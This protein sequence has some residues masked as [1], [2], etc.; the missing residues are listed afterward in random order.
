MTD[1]LT[2]A[3]DGS[4][5]FDMYTIRGF[6]AYSPSSPTGLIWLKSSGRAKSGDYAGSY[7][8]ARGY[9]YV[10]IAKKK[11]LTHRVV[12]AL[13]HGAID[14][15]MD[16]DHKDGNTS[17]NN[18]GNLRAAT[19]AENLKNTPLRKDNS[20][21]VKGLSW[22]AKSHGWVGR[23]WNEGKVH[24]KFSTSRSAVELWLIEMREKLHGEFA[25]H[26]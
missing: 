7:N 10:T 2:L 15:S 22:H 6:V 5:G 25:R 9:Y 17:N 19:R 20:S 16:V 13:N 26:T 1:K 24:R 21:G 8:D 12:W 18:I 4:G 3:V 14:S 11:Y 23:I